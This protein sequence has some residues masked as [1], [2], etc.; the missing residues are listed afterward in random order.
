LLACATGGDLSVLAG[1]VWGNANAK[2]G[3]RVDAIT[4][5]RAFAILTCEIR[6]LWPV[7]NRDF[8]PAGAENAIPDLS[9]SGTLESSWHFPT[10]HDPGVRVGT[11]LPI[12]HSSNAEGFFSLR[13]SGLALAGGVAAGA[14]NVRRL[15]HRLALRT[16]ILARRW[17]ARTHRMCA[18]FGW[19][20][21]HFVSPG[22]GSQK[23]R[24]QPV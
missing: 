6:L 5:A 20:A 8:L 23:G 24:S 11:G 21:S 15:F 22:C 1:F 16:A 9:S 12:V 2:V 13:L 4:S 10:P 3:R 17:H 7:S 19:L 14:I 18:L